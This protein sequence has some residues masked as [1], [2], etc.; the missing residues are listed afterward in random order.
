ML[1]FVLWT[2]AGLG[3]FLAAATLCVVGFFALTLLSY[4]KNGA[5]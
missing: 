4:N 5:P 3:I 1:T 2:L